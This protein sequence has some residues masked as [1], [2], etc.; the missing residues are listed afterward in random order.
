MSQDAEMSPLGPKWR[1]KKKIY[2]YIW[3]KEKNL[4]YSVLTRSYYARVSVMTKII[5][6]YWPN[7]PHRKAMHKAHVTCT[8]IHTH[9][10]SPTGAIGRVEEMTSKS[11][12]PRAGMP[13]NLLNGVM[14]TRVHTL[15]GLTKLCIFNGPNLLRGNHSSI[16]IRRNR[17]SGS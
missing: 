8:C 15:T 13:L 7:D 2:Q 16:K 6:G 5:N 3:F 4:N 14:I 9:T 12:F 10:R 17:Y 1:G 11:T